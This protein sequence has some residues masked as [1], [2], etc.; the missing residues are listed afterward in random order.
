MRFPFRHWQLG[1]SISLTLFTPAQTHA[2]ETV[3]MSYGGYNETIGPTWVAI[4]K[5]FYL[6]TRCNVFRT[7]LHF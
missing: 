4:D 1:I 7:K 5:G 3:L 6:L 2:E